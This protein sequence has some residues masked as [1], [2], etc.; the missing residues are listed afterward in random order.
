LHVPQQPPTQ[1][2]N[3]KSTRSEQKGAEIS[4]KLQ[5]DPVGGLPKAAPTPPA[6]PP[7]DPY[8]V[9]QQNA[10]AQENKLLNAPP[11]TPIPPAQYQAPNKYAMLGAALLTLLGGPGTGSALGAG[12][13][14]GLNQGEESKF[15]RAQQQAT[16]E[17]TAQDKTEAENEKRVQLAGTIASQQGNIEARQD[18]AQDRK[19]ALA[20]KH[21]EFLQT[22]Q[23]KNA[24]FAQ[25]YQLKSATL[26]ASVN[27]WQGQLAEM[28]ARNAITREDALAADSVHYQVAALND[29]NA[30]KRNAQNGALRVYL[31]QANQAQKQ[32]DDGLSGLRTAVSSG[33]MTPDQASAAAATLVQGAQARIEPL[34]DKAARI[35][36]SLTTAGTAPSSVP[37]PSDAGQGT[38][39]SASPGAYPSWYTQQLTPHAIENDAPRTPQSP[40]IKP[41]ADLLHASPQERIAAVTQALGTSSAGRGIGM[42]NASYDAA[43]QFVTTP[44]SPAFNEPS[45]ADFYQSLAVNYPA[46]SPQQAGQLG[47]AWLHAHAAQNVPPASAAAQPAAASAPAPSSLL[48][49]PGN[50][51]GPHPAASASAAA[52]PTYETHVQAYEP[53]T[54]GSVISHVAMTTPGLGKQ[55]IPLIAAIVQSESSGD[56]RATSKSGAIGLMQLMPGTAATLGVDPHDPA[57]NIIGG[58]QYLSSLLKR[59]GS[60]PLALA[61]Y[62]AGP[63][64]VMKY[65]G[66]PPFPETQ[67]YVKRVLGLYRQFLGTSQQ[68]GAI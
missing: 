20:E 59:F 37:Q 4:V 15:E 49:A 5:P 61:A 57:Q 7:S 64:A 11:P 36:A 8:V 66:I 29:A 13:L 24:Q 25:T 14:R 3:P 58:S 51:F 38:P 53:S 68:D 16:Q 60:I 43:R 23:E 52:Q 46:M 48:D 10:I 63:E 2:A 26:R 33:Q 17:N 54:I 40:T 67:Q 50:V 35:D 44:D 62:N 28:A 45:L 47:M 1:P 12:L 21:N 41:G 34:M 27:H 30:D 39:E 22:L 18:E 42:D 56:P 9:A 55:A 32:L 65:R 31:T 6:P 19:D